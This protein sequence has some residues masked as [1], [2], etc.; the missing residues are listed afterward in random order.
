MSIRT[1]T[2]E[3][4][5]IA[6]QSGDHFPDLYTAQRAALRPL[7]GDIVS[8]LRRLIADGV[9]VVDSGRVIVAEAKNK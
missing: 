1:R 6:E 9:L 8:T 7:A 2:H 4:I 5:I 3:Q